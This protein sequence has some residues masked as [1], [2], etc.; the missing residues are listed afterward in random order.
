MS[1]PAP[2][3]ICL[4]PSL[5]PA[6]PFVFS[7]TCWHASFRISTIIINAASLRQ[8]NK[9]LCLRNKERGNTCTTGRDLISNLAI[10]HRDL[11]YM[12]IVMIVAIHPSK[13]YSI[14]QYQKALGFS[15]APRVKLFIYY[16]WAFY[17]ICSSN[18]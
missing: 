5:V 12:L 4:L 3:P 14:R 11:L 18:V 15:V 2:L 1:P 10:L 17:G 6:R 13:G 9:T 16:L 7:W 8:L